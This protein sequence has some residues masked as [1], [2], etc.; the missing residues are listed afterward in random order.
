MPSGLAQQLVEGEGAAGRE[1]LLS[2]PSGRGQWVPLVRTRKGLVSLG[3]G[4][5]F[6]LACK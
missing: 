1:H 2:M 3:R 6:L 5:C 4:Q